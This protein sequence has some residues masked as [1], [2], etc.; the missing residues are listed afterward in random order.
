MDGRAGGQPRRADGRR[1]PRGWRLGTRCQQRLIRSR[2]KV[3]SLNFMRGRTFR[4]QAAHHRRSTEPDAQADETWPPRWPGTKVVCLGNIAQITPYLTGAHRSD[5]RG[6]SLQ[7][8][9]TRWPRHAATRRGARDLPT[10][11]RKSASAWPARSWRRP[12]GRRST[13]RL[14]LEAFHCRQIDD[15]L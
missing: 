15:R 9:G 10:T 14:R 1:Q 11:R 6:R 2:V 3:K 5:L 4:E 12:C 8:L 7:R 13:F